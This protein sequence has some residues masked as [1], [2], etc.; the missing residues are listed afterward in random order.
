[1]ARQASSQ[2]ASLA[3]HS[4]APSAVCKIIPLSFLHL[5]IRGEEE[6]G[7]EVQQ[8]QQILI[9]LEQSDISSSSRS[10]RKRFEAENG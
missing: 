8:Q 10:N 7:E 5:A 3:S 9:E 2:P 1:M 6:E 4:Y